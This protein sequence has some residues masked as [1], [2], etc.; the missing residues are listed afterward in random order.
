MK[1]EIL[2]NL[3]KARHL[4]LKMR[5]LA[6]LDPSDLRIDIPSARL[7]LCLLAGLNNQEI[8]LLALENLLDILKKGC[9]TKEESIQLIG[10]S[11]KLLK[12][13]ERELIQTVDLEAQNKI[14]QVYSV[15]A[16]TLHHHYGKKHIN[17]ITKELKNELVGSAKALGNLNRLED[18]RLKFN[19]NCALEGVRR[20]KDDGKELFILLEGIFHLTS[21]AVS[22]YFKDAQA[23]GSI[24][25]LIKIFTEIDWHAPLLFTKK[26]SWYSAVLVLKDC[27]QAI[28]LLKTPSSEVAVDVGFERRVGRVA[29]LVDEG[30]VPARVD[31]DRDRGSYA[32]ASIACAIFSSGST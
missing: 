19:V 11:I 1:L 16:E 32:G 29:A 2:R 3:K 14:A 28:K 25:K 17:G 13:M 5:Q 8:K 21:G 24:E 10:L 20:L 26:I 9:Y 27:T 23:F 30:G 12:L 15:L 6:G 18:A 7:G 4:I 31:E 22:L